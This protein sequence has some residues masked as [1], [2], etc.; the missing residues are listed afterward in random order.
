MYASSEETPFVMPR[1][2]NVTSQPSDL[3]DGHATLI[4][5]H[6]IRSTPMNDP[7]RSGSSSGNREDEDELMDSADS[8]PMDHSERSSTTDSPRSADDKDESMYSAD[9]GPCDGS[10]DG[11]DL[12]LQ[13]HMLP[14]QGRWNY[15]ILPVL[16]IADSRNIVPLLCS[17]LYQRHVWGIREPVVG[18]CCSNTGTIATTIFG[19]LDYDQSGEGCMVGQT[20]ILDLPH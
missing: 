12:P 4:A 2:Q 15:A 6:T 7:D 14:G 9:S 16:L 19:W 3:I 8:S 13:A 1:A 17:T 5:A 20:I 10:L 18:M 11:L